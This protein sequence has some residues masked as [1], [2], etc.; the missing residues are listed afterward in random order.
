MK[1]N[2]K[3]M[4][5]SKLMLLLTGIYAV[6]AFIVIFSVAAT[7][8]A[9][10]VMDNSSDNRITID[11]TV[12]HDLK[13]S[14]VPTDALD[15]CFSFDSRYCTYLYQGELI[16]VDMTANKTIKT[17]TEK[18]A[19]ARASLM[20][21][22]NI[23]IYCTIDKKNVLDV[24]TYTIE[25]DTIFDHK[26]FNVPKSTTVQQLDYSTTSSYVFMH[27]RAGS[28]S[29]AIDMVY[30]LDIMKRLHKTNL[31][32]LVNNMVQLNNS[33]RYYCED[34]K[35]ILHFETKNVK[36]FEKKKVRLL[37]CDAED[38]VYFQ[39][40]TDPTTIYKTDQQNNLSK[41]TLQDPDFAVYSDKEGVYVIYGDSIINL[42]GD[43]VRRMGY[44][45]NLSFIGMGGSNMF[46]R[47][48]D[49]D[50]VSIKKVI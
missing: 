2:R 5:R 31:R 4:K 34:S 44:D 19:I 40:M 33:I 49:G 39:D 36:G 47:N 26:S 29:K 43:K 21:D 30:Y 42:A 8:N 17:I 12:R 38:F 37:G 1:E 25:S 7:M 24:K 18:S 20:S 35:G 23:V 46:F 27:L 41:F 48:K 10:M 11:T 3:G 50:I 16:V 45:S 6:A 15:I 9:N 13:V 14:E 22:R 28:G 32:Y